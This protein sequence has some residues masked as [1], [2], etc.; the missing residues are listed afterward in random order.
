[1]PWLLYLTMHALFPSSEPVFLGMIC[2]RNDP[3]SIYFGLA[4]D[5]CDVV[6]EMEG[7]HTETWKAASAAIRLPGNSPWLLYE[8]TVWFLSFSASAFSHIHEKPPVSSTPV[9]QKCWMKTE[10]TWV[11]TRPVTQE[12]GINCHYSHTWRKHSGCQRRKRP[13]SATLGILTEL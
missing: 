7:R 12:Q 9:P 6:P 3:S 4:W 13:H 10:H 5:H 1:M 2:F 11:H 8:L